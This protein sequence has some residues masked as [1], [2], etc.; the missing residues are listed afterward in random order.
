MRAGVLTISEDDTFKAPLSGVTYDCQYQVAAGTLQVVV[1]GK[2]LPRNLPRQS[3]PIKVHSQDE[4]K[5]TF[6]TKGSIVRKQI[7]L[8][9]FEG[10][11][12]G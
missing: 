6:T 5:E 8:V 1:L 4:P 9:V 3:Y 7:D 12:K 2:L 11:L 10:P